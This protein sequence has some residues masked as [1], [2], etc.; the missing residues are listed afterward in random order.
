MITII[1]AHAQLHIWNCKGNT[2]ICIA[3]ILLIYAIG[4]V[5]IE[6]DNPL[7]T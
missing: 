4:H 6:N 2:D 7:Y 1:C 5:G 3:Y